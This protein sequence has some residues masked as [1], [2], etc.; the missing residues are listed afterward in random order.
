MYVRITHGS[1]DASRWDEFQRWGND[2]LVPAFKRMPGFRGYVGGGDRRTGNIIAVTYWE[3]E[4]QAQGL[5]DV[6]DPG[7]LNQIRELGVQL[8]AAEI[9]EVTVQV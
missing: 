9:Y 6:V 2:T 8:A 4:D 5:R 1:S 3:T 7:I